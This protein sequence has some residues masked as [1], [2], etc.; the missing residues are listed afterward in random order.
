LT[1]G[2][3]S[4]PCPGIASRTFRSAAEVASARAM[5]SPWCSA[6]SSW[7]ALRAATAGG[8]L[9]NAVS[10]PERSRLC[11]RGAACGYEPNLER[12]RLTAIPE[13]DEHNDRR[14]SDRRELPG[15][16]E[17]PGDRVSPEDRNMVGALIAA[18][19][20]AAAGVGAEASGIVAAR[21]LLTAEGQFSRLPHREDPDAI[22]QAVAGV[23]ELPVSRH[24]NLRREAAA[25]EARRETRE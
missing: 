14:V 24:E 9:S 22:V 2:R 25:R 10:D 11:S 20:K 12:L 7:L 5:G 17:P 4:A 19:E 18:V 6:S 3:R 16:G 1:G 13:I 23:N 21:P 8:A 15:E